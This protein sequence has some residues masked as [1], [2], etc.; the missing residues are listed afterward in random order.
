MKRITFVLFATIF[1]VAAQA[2][3]QA[4]LK[5]ITD[6]KE[7]W[8]FEFD[9]SSNKMLG[10]RDDIRTIHALCLAEARRDSHSAPI[11][12]LGTHWMSPS[13]TVT[14]LTYV[15]AVRGGLL[16]VLEKKNTAWVIVHQYHIPT[17]LLKP[18]GTP[19]KT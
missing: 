17:Y 13:Q 5:D 7:H 9:M 2:Q 1:V 4:G 15:D 8:L 19:D 18:H 12:G 14:K 3:E 6:N 16:F 11:G 10:T